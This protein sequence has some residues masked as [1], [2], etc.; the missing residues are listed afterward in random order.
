MPRKLAQGV[1]NASFAKLWL[2]DIVAWPIAHSS[3][4]WWAGPMLIAGGAMSG[5]YG[6]QASFRYCFVS[7]LD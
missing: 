2:V 7:S 3:C 1:E 5:V 4:T 6:Q